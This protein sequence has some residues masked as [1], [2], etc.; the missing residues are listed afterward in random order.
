MRAVLLWGPKEGPSFR[1]LELRLIPSYLSASPPPPWVQDFG[2]AGTGGR[3]A[4]TRRMSTYRAI[5]T[6]SSKLAYT[7]PIYHPKP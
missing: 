7:Q 2:V 1:E 3:G 4:Q 5:Q 6:P